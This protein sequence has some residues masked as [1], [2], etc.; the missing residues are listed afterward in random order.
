MEGDE[1]RRLLIASPLRFIK[2]VLMSMIDTLHMHTRG[3]YVRSAIYVTLCV[4]M[5][6]YL[7]FADFMSVAQNSM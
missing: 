7:A 6:I 5:L 2:A 1:E 4:C 3:N